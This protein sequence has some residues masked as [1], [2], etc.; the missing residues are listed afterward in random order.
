MYYYNNPNSNLAAL[1]GI[2]GLGWIHSPK[3]N[4]AEILLRIPDLLSFDPLILPSLNP[5]IL[6]S[7]YPPTV[8][9]STRLLV[10]PSGANIHES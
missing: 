8:Y 3:Y 10:Y 1:A 9:H 2:D 5:W 7:F 4:P 6:L